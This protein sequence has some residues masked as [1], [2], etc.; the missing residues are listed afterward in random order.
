MLGLSIGKT[1][2]IYES[3]NNTGCLSSI[4]KLIFKNLAFFQQKISKISYTKMTLKIDGLLRQ[5]FLSIKIGWHYENY[6][7]CLLWLL[8]LVPIFNKTGTKFYFE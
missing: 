5:M 3:T 6:Q 4:F 2:I 7:W 1:V 8:N